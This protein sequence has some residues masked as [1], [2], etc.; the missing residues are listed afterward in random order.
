MKTMKFIIIIY[1]LFLSSGCSKEWLEKKQDVKLIVPAELNDLEMLLNSP[2]FIYD[3][4]G[5]S[6]MSSDDAIYSTEQFNALSR[7]F[8]RDLATWQVSEFIQ[9]G[10]AN[11]DEWDIS[12]NQI[13]ICNVVLSTLEKI[14]RTNENGNLYDRIKGTALYHRSRQ[15]LNLS[16]TFCKYYDH[17]TAKTD[18]GIPLKLTDDIEEPIFRASLEDTY[19]RILFDLKLSC[20]LLPAQKVSLTHIAKAGAY[21][22]LARANLFMDQYEEAKMASDSSYKYHN[23]IEDYNSI[24][25]TVS[26][27]LNLQ[28]KEMHIPLEPRIAVSYATTGRI[29]NTLFNSY[30][31]DDLRRSLFFKLESDGKYSFRGHYRSAL[32]SGTTTPEVLLISAE[33]YAR[34]GNIDVAMQKLNLIL[35]KRFK[36]GTFVTRK[37]STTNEALD[38]ILL[39]RRKELVT[40]C[41]RWQ[42]LKRL[43]RDTRYAKTLERSIGTQ[44]YILPPNDPRY[45]LPI[46]QYI[47]NFN[48]IEQNPY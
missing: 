46:P 23:F 16:M 14:S 43:N 9:Y 6:E 38:M 36:K 48:T 37:A 7:D 4:R 33:C 39:E 13:Q 45:V 17:S 8:L 30:D 22:M 5:A 35:E 24:N 28:S 27:P 10:T 32:F 19:Q 34:L 20:N 44:H 26:R 40:R 3:G 12:Y 31:Q 15:F 25:S 21:A 29:N 47:I 11:Q 18:L 41:L 42:D 1:I 2:S